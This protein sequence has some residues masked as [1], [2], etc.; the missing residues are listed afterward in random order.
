[1]VF[2]VALLVALVLIALA[3]AIVST[4]LVLPLRGRVDQLAGDVSSLQVALDQLRSDVADLQTVAQAVPAPPLPKTRS[5]DLDDLRQ[6]L[7]AAH[8][9]SEGTSEE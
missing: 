3:L 1:M 5:G 9:E 7:R 2:A 6:R 8:T 4:W